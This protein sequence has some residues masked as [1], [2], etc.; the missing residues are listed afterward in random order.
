MR[1]AGSPTPGPAIASST[2]AVSRT[3]R[4][5]TCS[6]VVMAQYSPNSGPSVLRARLGLSPTS[7]HIDD[8][9]RIDP[10]MSLPWATATIPD[11]TAAAAPPL[12]PPGERLVSHGLRVGPYASGS[13]V[14]VD[15]SSGRLVL[16]TIT[17][18]AARK[19]WTSHVSFGSI[20]PA[21]FSTRIPQWYG[22]PA[23]CATASLIRNGTPRNGPSGNAAPAA[24]RA[25]SYS[26]VITAFSV[27]LSASMRPIAASTSSGGVTSPVA[28]SSACPVASSH[29]R[30]SA[31]IAPLRACALRSPAARLRPDH[32]FPRRASAK[33][34][35]NTRIW[36]T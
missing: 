33:A 23:V 34:S 17:N 14:T 6:C 18:P 3:V 32:R 27:G 21:S 26:G 8:G 35:R 1:L 7:P 9:T 12:E 4:V 36:R 19:R 2:A 11:A 13:V 25:F 10:P 24:A 30:S 16:P 5:S 15:A 22:S 20:Q 31:T 29:A 28:A